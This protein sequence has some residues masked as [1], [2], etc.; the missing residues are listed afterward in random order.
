M[1]SCS[2]IKLHKRLDDYMDQFI[3]SPDLRILLAF[4]LAAL[5]TG[6]IIP[7]LV[8]LAKK[9][10]LVAHQTERTSHIG[11]IPNLGGVALFSAIMLASWIFWDVKMI[12]SFQFKVVSILVI[13][14]LGLLDDM[15][16]ISPFKKFGGE[17]LATLVLI[18][19]GGVR[20][21]NLH[22]YFGISDI[23]YLSSICLTFFVFILIINAFNLI[24]GID[25][26]AAGIGIV[27]CATYGIW[28]WLA[29][30]TEHT[31]M[32]AATLGSLLVFFYFN[33]F[34]K[35]HKIFMGDTGSLVTG[36]VI[37]I[38]TVQFNQQ[39]I[40]QSKA[41]AI[42]AAP[43]VSI[44]ILIIPLFDTLRVFTL[45]I[46]AGQS[47]LYGD[48]RHLH[49]MLL[50][51]KLTHLQASLIMVCMNVFIIAIAFIYQS[52]KPQT[53]VFMGVIAAVILSYTF[54]IS[55]LRK[56]RLNINVH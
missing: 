45:R 44:A 55:I 51:L 56:R 48:K 24:D 21:T 7:S 2:V 19:L 53:L 32:A 11:S 30:Y 54:I 34:S 26:L 23:S 52:Y 5:I 18:M 20:I 27:C 15:I 17:I 41:F 8:N 42:Y 33:V 49:H 14:L 31:V 38:F 28:F 25:G 10:G 9:K 4:L 1:T 12:G 47:P 36:V 3:L 43:A 39:T 6:M 22:G 50:D 35:K 29:G 40:D 46:L 37:A 16:K 13:F